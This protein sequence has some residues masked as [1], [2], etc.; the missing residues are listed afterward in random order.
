MA[1]KYIQ[2]QKSFGKVQDSQMTLQ[3]PQHILIRVQNSRCIHQ[4][5]YLFKTFLD[6]KVYLC[7]VQTRE[8]TKS[9]FMTPV[10]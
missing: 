6:L 2:F 7:V 5:K 8:F 10:Y 3:Q 1:H 9:L 4:T